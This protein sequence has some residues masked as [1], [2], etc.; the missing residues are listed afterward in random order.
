MAKTPEGKYC[1]GKISLSSEDV[2]EHFKDIREEQDVN[3]RKDESNVASKRSSSSKS[4]SGVLV[5]LQQCPLKKYQ[6]HQRKLPLIRIK[7]ICED[8]PIES[9]MELASVAPLHFIL[10]N[11]EG[12]NIP[13]LVDTGAQASII[14]ENFSD[15][16][17]RDTD[18]TLQ[19]IQGSKLSCDGLLKV[20][21]SQ[22]DKELDLY[23]CPKVNY[24]IL[25]NDIL[26]EA[27]MKL[28]LSIKK[29]NLYGTDFRMFSKEELIAQAIVSNVEC[30]LPECIMSQVGNAPG[31]FRK[32][33]ELL[34]RKYTNLFDD[35]FLGRA[36]NFQHKIE[37]LE[38]RT[39]KQ[40]P[41]RLSPAKKMEVQQQIEE[42]LSKG[43]IKPSQSPFA[44]PIVLVSKKN[45]DFRMCVDFRKINA[46]TKIDAYPIPNVNEIFDDLNG[47]QFFSSI[48]L[49]SGFHQIPM[50][51]SDK[52]KT[53]FVVPGAQYEYNTMP[54]GLVNSSSTF[55]RVM[56][57]I[58]KDVIGKACHVFIDDIIIYARTFP[59]LVKN[60]DIVFNLISLAGMSLNSKKCTLFT[61]SV[62]LL[63]HR[64]SNNGI[65]PDESKIKLIQDWPVPKNKREVRA[66]LG[67]ASYYRRF[68]PNFSKIASPLSKL[69]SLKVNFNWNKDQ[70][71]AFEHL[72]RVLICYPVLRHFD[73]NK[74]VYI[75]ADASNEA[76]GGV[77][78]QKDDEGRDYAVSY[79][80][81]CLSA[82][83]KNYCVTRKELLSVIESLRY[84]KHYVQ[85][86]PHPVVVR[87]DHSSLQWLRN[88][89][90][91]SGQLARWL[92]KLAEFNFTIEHRK[93]TSALNAD[94]LSRRP[95]SHN[96]LHCTRREGQDVCISAVLRSEI[97]WKS[98]QAK[99]PAVSLILNWVSQGKKPEWEEVSGQDKIVQRFWH[100]FEMLSLHNDVLIRK[101]FCLLLIM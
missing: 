56:N 48:D 94:G 82:P 19:S 18:L 89:K 12:R 57:S 52:E 60:M 37:L 63:G 30:L 70:D 21:F 85:G 29:I 64:V 34:L 84:W 55:Q 67:T 14:Q 66:F 20:Y 17:L 73:F 72:K 101:F 95:C 93:G 97:N 43:I 6:S 8:L 27:K 44:S 28:D 11:V 59:E 39:I 32:Q 68:V 81:R 83:E 46:I 4:P 51:E 23:V 22:F 92:E 96:C 86:H 40:M 47:A 75:D 53:S 38:N 65:E 100:N 69:T 77:L 13:F 99:D 25:G 50:A 98:E 90:E 91:P 58:L 31:E 49:K 76:I 16:K 26:T 61:D 2:E 5:H 1:F 88:F 10:L 9:Q 79:F 35:R 87:S 45:G 3:S 24:N 36:H 42:L 33:S 78:T 62:I 80:S 54:F 71:L 15:E 74:P 7:C 41:Y